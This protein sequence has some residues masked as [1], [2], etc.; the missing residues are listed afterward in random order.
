MKLLLDQNLS[1]RFLDQLS[2]R[3]PSSTQTRVA[4]LERASD[5]QVVAVT[6]LR[7]ARLREQRPDAP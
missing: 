5:L 6:R 7:N 2:V 1:F 3:F 4:G